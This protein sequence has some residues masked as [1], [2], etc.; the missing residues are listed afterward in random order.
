MTKNIN[1][2]ETAFM[3]SMFRSMNEDLSKDEY[4]KLWNNAKTKLWVDDYLQMVSKEEVNTHCIRNRFFLETITRLFKQGLID[5]VINFGSGFSMYPFLLDKSI[6]HIEIDK[7]E[8]IDYKQKQIASWISL[9]KLPKRKI[10]FLGVDFSKDYSEKLFKDIKRLKQ[11]KHSLILI[12]GVLF[13]LNDS[14]T[15]TLFDFFERLQEQ[16]DYIGSVSFLHKIKET[17][18]FDRLINFFNTRLLKTSKEDF[19]TLDTNFYTRRT[20]YKVTEIEDYFSYS[21]KVNNHVTLGLE[22]V[23][24]ENFY[25]LQKENKTIK[26]V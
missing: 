25:V 8:I 16:G 7:P 14:Q 5:V 9:N 13:F 2:H 15:N 20:S 18:V 26:T 4:S 1:I 22:N 3:T 12:E 10:H 21:E 6:E 19:L 23:L 17:Q 11:D 24:N